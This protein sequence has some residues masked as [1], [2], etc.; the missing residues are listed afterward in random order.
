MGNPNR[1]IL[2]PRDTWCPPPG[3]LCHGVATSRAWDD[4]VLIWDD[5][6]NYG[7][8]FLYIIHGWIIELSVESSW[9]LSI[10]ILFLSVEL[11]EIGLTMHFSMAWSY[12]RWNSARDAKDWWW[13]SLQKGGNWMGFAGTNKPLVPP[14]HRS[15]KQQAHSLALTSSYSSCIDSWKWHQS[16]VMSSFSLSTLKKMT[17]AYQSHFFRYFWRGLSHLLTSS[18]RPTWNKHGC[19]RV[20]SFSPEPGVVFRTERF[21]FVWKSQKRIRSSVHIYIYIHSIYIYIKTNYDILHSHRRFTHMLY[22]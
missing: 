16:G 20:L 1:K 4:E 22:I 19:G 17:S 11:W 8:Q 13:V 3:T 10:I 14:L 15:R 6:L 18:P 12:P 9:I 5:Q 21:R 7:Q 2:Q